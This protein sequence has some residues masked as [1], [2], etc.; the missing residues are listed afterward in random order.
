MWIPGPLL[1]DLRQLKSKLKLSWSELLQE[2]RDA[3]KAK[4][5]R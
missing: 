5:K 3:H 1:A 2:L 4:E